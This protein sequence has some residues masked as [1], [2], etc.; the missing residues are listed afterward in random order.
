MNTRHIATP[1][2]LIVLLPIACLLVTGCGRTEPEP[3]SSS[4][5]PVK[6]DVVGKIVTS[7]ELILDL[8]HQLRSAARAIKNLE[9]PDYLSRELFADTVSTNPLK[10]GKPG[11]EFS[12]V[13]RSDLNLWPTLLRDFKHFEHAKFYMIKGHFDESDTDQFHSSVGFASLGQLN[14]DSWRAIKGSLE[15]TWKKTGQNWLIEKWDTHK[16]KTESAPQ[17]L[18]S[19]HLDRLIDDPQELDSLRT[20]QHM[21]YARQIFETG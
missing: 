11:T 1:P 9:L 10:D 15:L 21:Q 20:S 18:F 12:D 19:E 16:L 8:H 17:L 4:T 14:D 13:N 2:G 7:E 5:G 6:S 3:V